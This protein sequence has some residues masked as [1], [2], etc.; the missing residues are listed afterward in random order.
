MPES[1]KV[2]FSIRFGCDGLDILLTQFSVGSEIR[3]NLTSKISQ[4]GRA[5]TFLYGGY[6][7]STRSNRPGAWTFSESPE[8]VLAYRGPVL[9]ESPVKVNPAKFCGECGQARAKNALFCTSCGSKFRSSD[10]LVGDLYEQAMALDED[11][12]VLR[13]F[14]SQLF[15][16]YVFS[17]IDSGQAAILR[18]LIGLTCSSPALSR[19]VSGLEFSLDDEDISLG[20]AQHLA[21]KLNSGTDLS[22]KELEIVRQILEFAPITFGYWGTIKAA[23]KKLPMIGNEKYFGVALANIE[24]APSIEPKTGEASFE[25]LWGLFENYKVPTTRTLNYMARRIRRELI[26]LAK[27]HPDSYV[28][29]AKHFAINWEEPYRARSFAAGFIFHGGLAHLNQTSRGVDRFLQPTGRSEAFP[30]IWNRHPKAV[31]EILSSEIRG[32]KA[33]TMAFQI[34]EDQGLKIPKLGDQQLK[35][36]I[37]SAHRPLR[38][39]GIEGL[40]AADYFY[41]DLDVATWNAFFEDATDQQLERLLE[42]YRSYTFPVNQ[43]SFMVGIVDAV[44]NTRELPPKRRGKLA[45]FALQNPSGA[46]WSN[47][48]AI[49]RI[50]IRELGVD[51]FRN[52]TNILRH[53]QM[54]ELVSLV[55]WLEEQRIPFQEVFDAI[56][57]AAIRATTNNYYYRTSTAAGFMMLESGR[58]FEIAWKILDSEPTD[59]VATRLLTLD[60]IK[61]L[62]PEARRRFANELLLHT[63]I[64]LIESVVRQ[65]LDY[66]DVWVGFDVV[67]ALGLEGGVNVGWAILGMDSI[68][69]LH[70]SIISSESL[71]KS[72]GNNLQISEL[73]AASGA[74]A[75]LATSYLA[76]DTMRVKIDPEFVLA[77]ATSASP[78]LSNAGI[79]TLAAND[80]LARYWMR[81]AESGLPN[82]LA[83]CS[84]HIASIKDS[85]K[86][87]EA[88]MAL[89]DSAADSAKKLGLSFLDAP[90]SALDLD[91]IWGNLTESDDAEILARVSEEALVRGSIPDDR[92]AAMDR[93]VLV[94]RRKSRTAKEAIKQRM[95]NGSFELAPERAKALLELARAQNSRDREWAISRLAILSINGIA[96]PNFEAYQTSAAG[97]NAR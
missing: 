57:E 54:H 94:S 18:Q 68:S 32:S 29:V 66:P 16:T 14:V 19:R 88:I 86:L 31:L 13:D 82:C 65:L 47:R 21:E 51:L 52:N 59:D 76:I 71:V 41:E 56:S 46:S 73:K 95:D 11:K 84:E 83:A 69:E 55:R 48:L 85:E 12:I 64:Q 61:N 22:S 75:E 28:E 10:G 39:L 67:E 92:L 78:A 58:G 6:D 70:E 77:A 91:T 45:E 40:L 25:S 79:R 7:Y 36:A 90:S 30:E 87:T 63:P 15:E 60:S 38:E 43:Y 89:L 9:Y 62:S 35:Y 5:K 33:L 80:L 96:V 93:R 37:M 17:S 2:D 1:T 4:W 34:A 44:L 8:E 23:L 27:S 42:R 81:L 24:N 49:T 72:I 50:A 26:V 20:L 74:Q 53:F 97:E 3:I